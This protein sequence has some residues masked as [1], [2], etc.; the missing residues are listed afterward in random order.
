VRDDRACW[1]RKA[2]GGLFSYLLDDKPADHPEPER[3]LCGMEY[4]TVDVPGV[5]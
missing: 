3:N 1:Q 5:N 4:A 2:A